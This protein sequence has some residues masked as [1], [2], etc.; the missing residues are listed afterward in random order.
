MLRIPYNYTVPY[1]D[2]AEH[3]Q[4]CGEE[5]EEINQYKYKE[6]TKNVYAPLLTSRFLFKVYQTSSPIMKHPYK[7][8]N[9][10]YYY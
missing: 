7:I 2:S 6:Q 10:Y 4:K 9:H 8:I 1:N 3:Q 5:E